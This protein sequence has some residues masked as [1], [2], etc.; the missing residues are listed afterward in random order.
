VRRPRTSRGPKGRHSIA[1]RERA[2]VKRG[3][4]VVA[5]QLGVVLEDLVDRHVLC[6]Q[7]K[8]H[9]DGIAQPTDRGLA[10]ADGWIGR[11]AI[12][13]RHGLQRTFTPQQ[14]SAVGCRG[15][16]G[17]DELLTEPAHQWQPVQARA[18]AHRVFA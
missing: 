18:A 8:K 10:V 17:R 4:E 6:H 13:A 9:L 11:N 14:A 12:E 16:L 3:K 15:L 1:G 7:L 5:F 2:E